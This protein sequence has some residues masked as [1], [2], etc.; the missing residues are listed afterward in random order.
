MTDLREALL[1][2]GAAS[3]RDQQWY[4]SGMAAS[5]RYWVDECQRR[6]RVAVALTVLVVLTAETL[7]AGIV[8]WGRSL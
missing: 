5:K 3:K 8:F 2:L 7:F 6:V 4:E 1:V